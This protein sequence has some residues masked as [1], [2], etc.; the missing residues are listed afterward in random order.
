MAIFGIFNFQATEN[1]SFDVDFLTISIYI[2][3]YT[4]YRLH[5]MISIS[6]GNK[7]D[8]NWYQFTEIRMLPKLFFVWSSQ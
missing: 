2:Y 8:F 5:W 6:F 4:I 3:R 7:L 1:S